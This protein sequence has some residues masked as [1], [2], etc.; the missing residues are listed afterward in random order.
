MTAVPHLTVP[1]LAALAEPFQ[2]RDLQL[3]NRLAMAPMTRR[4]SP[5][6]IPTQ[7]VADYY[8][9]RAH[10]GLLIT[11]GTY[12]DHPSSGSVTTVPRLAGDAVLTGWRRVVEAVH[13]EG[14]RIAVQLWHLGLARTDDSPLHPGFPALSPS[15]ITGPGEPH[16]RA[17]TTDDLA[18]LLDAY[19]RATVAAREVG[20]D[21]VE[22]HGAH[23]YLLDSFM[24]SATNRRTDHYGGDAAGRSRFPAEV[25]ATLRAAAG[26]LPVLYRFSQWKATDYR[27]RIA[28]TPDEL[29]ALL[30]P[31]AEAGVDA[32]HASTR[33]F[34]E[35]AFADSE[36]TL[37]GWAKKLTG[38]PTVAVGSVGIDKLFGEPI[39]DAAGGD[40]TT[41]VSDAAGRIAAGEFDLIAVG[42][43]VLADPT[44]GARVLSG[45]TD[46]LRQYTKESERTLDGV[47][48][49]S[50]L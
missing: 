21:A 27:A 8:A 1:H 42:R 36:L 22:I 23:G 45:E 29:A 17:A 10:L 14:G 38:V 5:D 16:G 19:A 39:G 6:G 41:R 32:F 35:P 7:A 25:V 18:E 26:Q 28:S 34:W 9:R 40:P 30:R 4:F 33:R 3:P 11:E 49:D 2:L 15:G 48:R 12:L 44:W 46:Q 20:F 50:S 24:W 31:L 47:E 13:A 37:A 43:A